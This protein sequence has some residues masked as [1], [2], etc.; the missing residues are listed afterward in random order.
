VDFYRNWTDYRTGFL[1]KNLAGE[2]WLGEKN[3][4]YRVGQKNPDC[5]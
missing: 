5:V 1:G 4:I 3:N 2:F